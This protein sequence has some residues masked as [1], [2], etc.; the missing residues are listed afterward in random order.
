MSRHVHVPKL[1]LTT[2]ALDF[3]E[4]V[5]CAFAF[6]FAFATRHHDNT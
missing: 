5:T 3:G 6:A 1:S 4:T 2:F